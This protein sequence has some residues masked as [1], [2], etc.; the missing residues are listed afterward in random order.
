MDFAI[1]PITIKRNTASCPAHA[2]HPVRR[3]FAIQ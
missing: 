2:Q 1:M 3:G